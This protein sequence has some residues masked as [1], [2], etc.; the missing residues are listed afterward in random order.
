MNEQKDRLDLVIKQVFTRMKKSN[1]KP[2][3]C[4]G[5]ELLAAYHE[6]SLTGEE[7]ER[8]EEHLVLC[9][10]CT[11]N[12]IVLSE[13]VSSYDSATES[14][15]TE[16]MVQ[17]AKDLIKPPV[18]PPLWERLSSWFISF[19]PVPV[20]AAACVCLVLVIVGV[21][22]YAPPGGE[23]PIALSMGI[24]ARLPSGAVTKGKTPVFKEVEIEDGGVLH[25]GDLFRI[26][27]KL[28]KEAY[29]YLLALNARGKITRIFPRKDTRVDFQAKPDEPYAIPQGDE[30]FRLDDNTGTETFYLFASPNRIED[31]DQK[32]AHL[33]KPGPDELKKIFP[34]VKIQPFTLKHE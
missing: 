33:K 16:K 32:V 29:V 8:I 12:L 6:G 1:P 3:N 21:Y 2:G 11:E 14:I 18:E 19:R 4:P 15:T 27:F 24:I 13:I 22:M 30:W 7:T 34:E 26:K 28:R 20:M 17:R 25:S 31:I 23:R 5:D 10:R 9:D